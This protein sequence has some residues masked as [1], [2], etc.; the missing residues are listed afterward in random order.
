MKEI[1]FVVTDK[2]EYEYQNIS[3]KLT[4]FVSLDYQD[5]DA[6]TKVNNLPINFS[7]T[8]LEFSMEILMEEIEPVVTEKHDFECRD[9]SL[10][11]PLFRNFG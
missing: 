8:N 2:H 4:L 6:R 9:N 11:K 10:L 1:K 5:S 3:L 7:S